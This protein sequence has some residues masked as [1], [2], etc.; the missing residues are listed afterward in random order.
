MVNR[1]IQ[2]KNYQFKVKDSEH[3]LDQ[4]ALEQLLRYIQLPVS[5]LDFLK[6]GDN[7]WLGHVK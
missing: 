3:M 7:M 6:L 5:Y 4:N 2:Y 1:V